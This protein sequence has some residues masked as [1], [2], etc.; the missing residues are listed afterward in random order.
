MK[1]KKEAAIDSQKEQNF[2]ESL[3]EKL[4][5]KI[6][7]DMR[8]NLIRKAPFSITTALIVLMVLLA[9]R[10]LINYAFLMIGQFR[11]TIPVIPFIG[12][13]TKPTLVGLILF[14][15]I[16]I[17]AWLI[18]TKLENYKTIAWRYTIFFSMLLGI[19]TYYTWY[20]TAPVYNHI[21]PYLLEQESK[22]DVVNV[23]HGILTG[24]VDNLIILLVFVPSIIV[25]ML[26]L[27]A[28]GQYSMHNE[29]L[30]TR[31]EEFE[32][33]SRKLQKFFK[34]VEEE[35]FPDVVLGPDSDTNESIIQL[36]KDRTLNNCIIGSIG[37]GKTAA[38]VLPILNQDL[39]W[40]TKFINA[41]PS[42]YE[43]E[44]YH[45]EDVKGSYLNGISVIEPS[46]DLCQKL[47]QLVKA[48][49]I[50]EEA[51]FYIDPTDPNTP[52][53]NPMQ[54]PVE[55]VAEA[56]AMVI[57]GLAEGGDGGNFFFQ[58]SER[59]HLKHY[60]Y[61]LKLHEPTKEVTFDMLL[62]MYNNSQ[63]VRKMHETL[64]AT[65]PEN[66]DSIEG[67]DERNHWKIVQQIDEWFDANLLPMTERNGAPVKVTHG[68]H[69][70]EDAYYDAKSEY[71]QGLRNIL[72]DIGSNLLIRRVL[73]GKSDFNFDKHLEFG[74]VLLVNTA[75]GELA[76]LSNVLGKLVLLSLQ[77]AV[78]RREPATSNF[79]HI[80]VD[81]FPDYIYQPFKEFP[82]QSRKYK[83]IVTVVAQ[84]IAQ[85]ADKYGESYMHTLLGT[86]R[87][88]MVYGDIPDYDA[89]IFSKIFG[90]EERFEESMSEQAVSALQE[91][92]VTRAGSSYTKTVEA[93]MSPSDIMYQ[94]EFQCAIK[95]VQNNRPIPV[96]QIDAN[97][98]PR[99][100]F[101]ASL[102][103]VVEEAGDRWMLER[104]RF[105]N[106][107][108]ELMEEGI[109]KVEEIEPENI[110]LQKEEKDTFASIV[111]STEQPM[112]L[113][114]RSS[115]TKYNSALEQQSERVSNVDFQKDNEV[116]GTEV[117]KG[118]SSVGSENLVV[119][120]SREED[121]DTSEI[122]DGEYDP[123]S[124]IFGTDEGKEINNELNKEKELQVSQLSEEHEELL[125]EMEQELSNTN[126]EDKLD[127]NGVESLMGT[128]TPEGK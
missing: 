104:N 14:T 72:N 119:P 66:I 118:S 86:L 109:E 60:I 7:E 117:S 82:A 63:L 16:S 31:F 6:P 42:L 43:R 105:L 90:E 127:N 25:T 108:M 51:V 84:T 30:K 101:K 40:M 9:L 93:I 35:K 57:A 102:F 110:S 26:M 88:K 120:A 111:P 5:D 74:G 12:D 3:I 33:K 62:D 22:L 52:S 50:P 45:T 38:L 15:L 58:Q 36:G 29:D 123:L 85:L 39:H 126:K 44:D 79:H 128:F 46:N 96:R 75:K 8:D 34:Q 112:E 13:P 68:I 71:V 17:S 20:V 94:K 65:F 61:L 107:T 41:Y 19:T 106:N 32:F 87:H 53:I 59:N 124:D 121:I 92:P 47:F 125:K 70:G 18:S 78:F 91:Q 54:G 76:G 23:W 55:Q 89:E 113:K 48:H 24:N 77:N 122:G 114:Y 64:K 98:V 4:K 1:V 28:T 49:H 27:W 73:F 116:E 99:E 37:T 97:F 81:E 80:L 100:E 2:L 95:I 10:T 103:E 67:R 56:F 83:T 115:S 21:A 69:R 11:E